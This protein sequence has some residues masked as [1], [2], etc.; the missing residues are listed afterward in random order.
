MNIGVICQISLHPNTAAAL[1]PCKCVA[2]NL[3]NLAASSTNGVDVGVHPDCLNVLGE[4]AMMWS[5]LIEVSFKCNTNSC[6]GNDG[7]VRVK[8]ISTW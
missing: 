6:R 3:V 2:A 7:L 1:K 4:R 8:K 5:T